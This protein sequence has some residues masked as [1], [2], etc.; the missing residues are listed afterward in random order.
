M[1]AMSKRK[2]P[3]TSVEEPT[4]EKTLAIWHQWLNQP[5]NRDN[6]LAQAEMNSSGLFGLHCRLCSKTRTKSRFGVIAEGHTAIHYYHGDN[7]SRWHEHVKS[8]AH[9]NAAAK[10]KTLLFWAQQKTTNSLESKRIRMSRLFMCAYKPLSTGRPTQSF[11]D[12]A[13]LLD[14]NDVEI[15]SHYRNDKFFKEASSYIA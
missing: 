5:V 9:R 15:N 6:G 10:E 7:I 4:S 14:A 2:R 3:Q 11:L 12:D 13:I 8:A 1:R